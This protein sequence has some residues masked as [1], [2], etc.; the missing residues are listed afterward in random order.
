LM[1]PPVGV[2]NDPV[3]LDGIC[4][5]DATCATIGTVIHAKRQLIETTDI[6]RNLPMCPRRYTD[7]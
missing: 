4:R 3:P 5:V 1:N 6:A 2:E 7:Y